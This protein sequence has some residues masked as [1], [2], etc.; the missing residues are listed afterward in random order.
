M[1]KYNSSNVGERFSLYLRILRISQKRISQLSGV[2]ESTV[3]RFCLG[4]PIA[5]DNLQKLLLVS[6]DL[7]LEWLFMGRGY[8]IIVND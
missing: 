2:P 1:K 8:P 5:S 3:S 6:D 7:S 4:R